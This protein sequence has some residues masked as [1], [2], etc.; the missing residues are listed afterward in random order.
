M[1]P[2]LG[3]AESIERL[4]A[5]PEFLEA[6]IDAAGHPENFLFQPAPGEFSLVEHACHLRDLEREGYLVR[7]RRMAAE[8]GPALQSFDGAAIAAARGYRGQDARIAAQEF[9]A[10]RRELV[11]MLAPLTEEDMARQATFDGEPVSF[12]DMI[13]MMVEHDRGHREEIEHLIDRLE[14][15]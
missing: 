8:D 4:D 10:A 14:E 11:G 3:L 15:R 13:A 6:A 9:G 5:M 12:G 7:V 2:R 1:P